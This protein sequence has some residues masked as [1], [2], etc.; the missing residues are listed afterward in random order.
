MASVTDIAA[1]PDALFARFQM[2]FYADLVEAVFK[3]LGDT[4]GGSR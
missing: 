4:M 1:I 2:S 3:D